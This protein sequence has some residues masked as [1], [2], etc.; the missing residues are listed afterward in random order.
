MSSMYVVCIA[1][2]A[3]LV[4]TKGLCVPLLEETTPMLPPGV[5]YAVAASSSS[6]SKSICNLVIPKWPS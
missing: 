2:I 6:L 4:F 5:N 3:V 1:N